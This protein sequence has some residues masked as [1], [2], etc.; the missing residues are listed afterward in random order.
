MNLES[1]LI[2]FGFPTIHPL[3][4]STLPVVMNPRRLEKE[5]QAR[6]AEEVRKLDIELLYQRAIGA[7]EHR[8]EVSI[9]FV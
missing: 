3:G 7:E 1:W 4:R 2:S 6:E 9:T 5:T 8:R